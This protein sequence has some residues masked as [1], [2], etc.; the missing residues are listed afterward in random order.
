MLVA[1][2]KGGP[3]W[4]AT[5]HR[6]GLERPIREFCPVI[7]EATVLLVALRDKFEKS[8]AEEEKKLEQFNRWRE[9]WERAAR[10]RR[11]ITVYAQKSRSFPAEKQSKY[12]EW[13]EWATRE[14]DRL[15]PFVSEK[16]A[17]VLDS[18]LQARRLC[19][20]TGAVTA[21]LP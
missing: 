9:S 13:I 17:S 7:V 3:K 4:P 1:R 15:D 2:V 16:P 20:Q 12:R 10:L 21:E 11:F 8:Y 19:H 5:L 6:G 14:A 18:V